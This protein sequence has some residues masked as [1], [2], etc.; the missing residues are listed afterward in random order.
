MA[1]TLRPRVNRQQP[2]RW[3]FSFSYIVFVDSGQRRKLHQGITD[4]GRNETP[5]IAVLSLLDDWGCSES[6]ATLRIYVAP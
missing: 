3:S 6:Q 2:G 4:F 1:P 5:A